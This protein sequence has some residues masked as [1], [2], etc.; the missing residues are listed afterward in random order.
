MIETDRERRA[1]L[2]AEREA[3]DREDAAIATLLES[4]PVAG[5]K[6]LID[7]LAKRHNVTLHIRPRM[8]SDAGGLAY[9]RRRKIEIPPLDDHANHE[10]WMAVALHELAHNLAPA[11]EGDGHHVDDAAGR[12]RH[13][14]KCE[15]L[16]WQIAMT[17][18]RF[19]PGMYRT[20][21]ASLRR[22]L[23]ATTAPAVTRDM[24]EYV[25]SDR[26]VAA[27]RQRW[28]DHQSRVERQQAA[29]AAIFEDRARSGWF[30]CST[31]GCRQRSSGT[32]VSEGTARAACT[33]CR[34]D[35]LMADLR[36]RR[37]AL[38]ARPATPPRRGLSTGVVR[39]DERGRFVVPADGSTPL[40]VAADWFDRVT[41]GQRV[42]HRVVVN[43]LT[44]V[45]FAVNA[46]E[47]HGV[48]EGGGGVNAVFVG[49]TN[50]VSRHAHVDPGKQT[51]LERPR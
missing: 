45:P 17:L 24:V 46:D 26:G 51:S 48:G 13:C 49:A 7:V 29:N 11:C 37:A 4:D 32:I 44:G 28:T 39:I 36:V 21:Q 9:R 43:R 40:R 25:A 5:A 16:A 18:H 19:T 1:R 14:L 2:D 33:N 3:R 31:P 8:P 35:A 12:Y 10:Q 27:D 38:T 47:T 6:L 20:M 42:A 50:H 22:N 23:G 15:G 30:G 41:D 34:S